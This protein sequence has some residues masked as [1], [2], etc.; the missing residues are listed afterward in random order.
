MLEHLETLVDSRATVKIASEGSDQGTVR[1]FLGDSVERDVFDDAVFASCD[2]D[3]L[4]P[5]EHEV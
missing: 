2:N 1:Q 3:S 5:V 4:L